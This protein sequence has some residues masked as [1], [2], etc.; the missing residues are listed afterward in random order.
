MRSMARPEEFFLNHRPSCR[1]WA[2]WEITPK[3]LCFS[4][5]FKT[6]ADY[7]CSLHRVVNDVW[8]EWFQPTQCTKRIQTSLCN[9]FFKVIHAIILSWVTAMKVWSPRSLKPLEN[10]HEMKI[11][12]LFHVNSLTSHRHIKYR[13]KLSSLRKSA[14]WGT[15]TS[16]SLF[17]ITLLSSL[18]C[19]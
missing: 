12:N 4:L 15:L 9:C 18:T 13:W 1:H 16:C 6:F 14:T 17:Q 8:R 3:V 7:A 19:D 10:Q 5:T 2:H 11:Y